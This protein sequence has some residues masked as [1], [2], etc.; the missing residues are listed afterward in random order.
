MNKHVLFSILSTFISCISL[1]QQSDIKSAYVDMS[2]RAMKMLEK[3]QGENE[4]K[5]YSPL[6]LEMAI[7]MLQS[8]ASGATLEEIHKSIGIEGCTKHEV[9]VYNKQILDG[10][11]QAG[12][13]ATKENECNIIKTANALYLN[14]SFEANSDYVLSCKNLY[15]ALVDNAKL[16][17]IDDYKKIDAWCAE[18]TNGI[19]PSL[20]LQPSQDRAMLLLNLLV[21]NAQ[22]EDEFPEY[23]PEVNFYNNGTTPVSIN[24][25]RKRSLNA[26]AEVGNFQ[27][28][29]LDYNPDRRF[30][31]YIYLSKDTLGIDPL[32]TD[33]WNA[34][35]Q[36]M[37]PYDT[38]LFLPPFNANINVD[39]KD[40]CQQLG[41]HS[42]F[43]K[44]EAD[45]SDITDNGLFHIEDIY[46]SSGIKTDIHGTMVY[47]ATAVYADIPTG[48][49]TDKKATVR[50]NHPFYF[51]IEDNQTSSILYMGKINNITDAQQPLKIGLPTGISHLQQGI[52]NEHSTLY[53]LQGRKIEAKPGKGIYV[54]D[55]K[56]YGMK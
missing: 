46:Q 15:D 35:H 11:N 7:G 33:V 26:Y 22:W 6:S 32:T 1:A 18:Q 5:V 10:L 52:G 44:G 53:D 3:S 19:I 49:L 2:I 50:V 37:E 27:V 51:T 4:N 13:E 14:P 48:D 21:F 8:G 47:N 55:G 45:F 23:M 39:M 30:S 34:S 24:T 40:I 28:V 38:Y 31:M 41:M 16:T 42:L 29:R 36:S 56:K 54:K 43:V 12:L 9:D 17:A 20:N 25:M